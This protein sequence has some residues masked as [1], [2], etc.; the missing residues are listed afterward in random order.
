[1]IEVNIEEVILRGESSPTFF[2]DVHFDNGWK[3]D[4]SYDNYDKALK[5]KAEIQKEWSEKKAIQI[6]DNYN[7][8]AVE[9]SIN[10]QALQLH[11]LNALNELHRAKKITWDFIPI[12][13]CIEQLESY[14]WKLKEKK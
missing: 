13:K 11:I 14:Y 12:S 7:F 10:E 9:K 3:N 6:D 8:S 1:M 2:V 4:S 5:R